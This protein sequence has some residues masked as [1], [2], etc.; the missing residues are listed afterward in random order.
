VTTGFSW[1]GG[2][3]SGTGRLILAEGTTSTISGTG[4]KRF[5]TTTRILE[6]RGTLTYNGSGLDSFTSPAFTSQISRI[7]NTATGIWI[8]DGDGDITARNNGNQPGA[9]SGISFENAGLVRRF[10]AGT[11]TLS[12]DS[13]GATFAN[14]GT[15]QIEAGSLQLSNGITQSA[16]GAI[17]HL[18]GGS[19][20]GGSLS[21][22]NGRITGVGT[23]NANVTNSGATISP[24]PS[25]T[26]TI[27]I[28]GNYTQQSGGSLML[29]LDGDVASGA[30]DKLAIS[31]TTT[32][33]GTVSLRS[34]LALTNEVFPL[35]TYA[36]RTGSFS[37]ITVSTNGTA[38]ATYLPT[39]AEFTVSSDVLGI[40]APQLA[41]SY[42][43]WVGSVAQEWVQPSA[44]AMRMIDGAEAAAPPV[45]WDDLPGSDPDGD[46]SSNLLEY[47]FQTNPLDPTSFMRMS[48]CRDA[49]D[50][51]CLAGVCR[52]RAPADDI[53]CSLEVSDDLIHWRPATEEPTHVQLADEPSSGPGIRDLRIRLNT[54]SAPAKHLRWNVRLKN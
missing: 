27:S 43:D 22:A 36:S 34:S 21:F 54:A 38:T 46:G 20:S 49:S 8:F 28:T 23:I 9:H 29:D 18:A 30:F 41:S 25:G 6:N 7:I 3:M 5:E 52:L 33:S 2:S 45:T 53:E 24:D 10:G 13:L 14:S 16:A 1:S 51:E 26:R 39:R 40:P 37:S 42:Q 17:M 35:V 31:G 32:I 4:Q 11:T 15:V 47:A 19:L 12:S 44:S 50:T 48:F